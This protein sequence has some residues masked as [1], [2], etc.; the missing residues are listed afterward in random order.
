MLFYHC[1][2]HHC[3][4]FIP[5]LYYYDDLSIAHQ[6]RSDNVDRYTNNRNEDVKRNNDVNNIDRI[7]AYNGNNVM[8]NDNNSDHDLIEDNIITIILLKIYKRNQ[9]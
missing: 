2:F 5:S 3:P 7:D 8:N 4:T 1:D 6:K 9:S